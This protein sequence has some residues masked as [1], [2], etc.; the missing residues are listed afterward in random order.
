LVQ[1]EDP[2]D[3]A[4]EPATQP[5]QLLAPVVAQKKPAAQLTQVK[6]ATAPVTAENFPAMQFTHEDEPVVVE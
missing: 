3:A 1:A 5:E 6:D 2:E 4:K